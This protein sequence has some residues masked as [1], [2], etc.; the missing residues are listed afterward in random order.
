MKP[1]FEFTAGASPLLVSVP[2]S[3]TYVPDDIARRLT[4]EAAAMPDTDWHVEKLYAFAPSIGASYLVANYSRYAI[5]LNR[6]P[7]GKPLYPG[8]DNTELVPSSTF[9]REPVY[10]DG[11]APDAAEIAERVERFWRPYH[12]ALA[13]EL[14]AIRARHGIAVLW[15]GHSI[16]SVVPRFFEGRL[17]DLN[18]GSASGAS[19]DAGLTE[20][21]RA[22][23]DGPGMSLVVNGRF[24]G[25]YI[26]RRYG[27]PAG[28]VHALQLEK[29]MAA[30]MA[31]S[32]P[33]RWDPARA[34]AMIERLQRTM[35]AV[36]GW[37]K[38]HTTR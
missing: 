38:E 17:P 9:A 1:I 27:T 19:A 15:D 26:T 4:P 8:A 23:L 6:D 5:D 3:G 18:L 12:A 2:H 24:K 37:A 30:Y 29:A 25:G 22:A 20:C 32:P 34:A 36:L 7:A 33:Y 28:G 21:A 16:W 35:A 10:R 14:D 11:Q 31:E 13:A